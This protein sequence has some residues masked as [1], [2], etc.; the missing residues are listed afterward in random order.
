MRGG[1]HTGW[2]DLAG[3]YQAQEVTEGMWEFSGAGDFLVAPL[4]AQPLFL[5][6]E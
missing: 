3:L 1:E 6:H 4:F 5:G 2:Q